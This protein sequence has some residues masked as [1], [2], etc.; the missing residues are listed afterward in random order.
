M[1]RKRRPRNSTRTGR[2]PSGSRFRLWGFRLFVIAVCCVALYC[3]WL[4]YLVRIEF[5]G[6]RWALPARVY[7][8]PMELYVGMSVSKQDLVY[9]LAALGYQEVS[10]VTRPGQY[11]VTGNSIRFFNREFSF[12]DG[13]QKSANTD[14]TL[15]NGIIRDL[16]DRVTGNSVSIIR[17]VPQLI[18]KIY[19]AHNEDRVLVPYEDIPVTLIH[20][21]I[22]VE[23]RNFYDHHGI[24]PR[25]IARALY[26]N[27]RAGVV[28]QGGSTLTQQLVKNFYLDRER[29]LWRKINEMI[30]AV[31]LEWH[32]SKRDILSAYSNEVY[33]GQHGANSIHGFGTASEFYFSRPLQE[34]SLD[35]LAVLVG[36]VKGASYYN[37][38][39]HPRRALERRNLVIGMMQEQGF[40]TGKE[41]RQAVARDLTVTNQ[42]H[43]S[44]AKYPAYLDLVRRHLQ[45]DYET[46]ELRS[47]GLQ[48]FTTLV[49]DIQEKAGLATQV[50]LNRLEK[51][52]HPDAKHLQAALLVTEISTGE[53][54][55]IIGG[56]DSYLPGFNRALDAKRPIGSLV[57]PAIY[58]TVLANPAKYNVLSEI[59]DAPITIKQSNKLTWQPENYGGKSHGKVS[60]LT[61]MASS[62][63]LATVRLGMELG[64]DNIRKTLEVLGVQS[65]IPVYPSLLL[66]AVELSPYEITQMYQTIANGG[67]KVPLNTVS[68]VLDK[69]GR[70]LK[71]YGLEIEQ[72]AESEPVFLTKYLM[73]EV[74]NTGTGKGLKTRLAD[75]MPLAGKTGTTND[76]RDSWF[77]GFGDRILATAWVGRDDNKPAG[78]TGASGAMQVW[79]DLMQSIRPQ[80][81]MLDAPENIAWINIRDGARTSRDCPGTTAYPFIRPYLPAKS[82]ECN[83]DGRQGSATDLL[84]MW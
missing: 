45:R 1:P 42:S 46:E 55:A 48:I 30:M 82:V 3:L 71:R 39:Q 41:A 64:I 49:P 67:F 32:Y 65:G 56:R 61:A 80:P 6:K 52:K 43:W 35:Q 27:L 53:I 73:T 70:S 26:A 60:L 28:I 20:A 44:S 9:E 76:L 69:N 47:E 23:D 31:M 34:L 5:E 77:V 8:S 16:K 72:V 4:D 22:A 17:L 63:N 84:R 21:L 12:W 38:R 33:L 74:V 15:A 51:T 66:G 19:P 79:S 25:G 78:L 36:L 57:K 54:L 68:A 14:L 11:A 58:M 40:V 18:G 81:L 29:T 62:Y 2:T 24:D 13:I 37:P 75:F 10:R 7:A 59:D 50:V 83:T